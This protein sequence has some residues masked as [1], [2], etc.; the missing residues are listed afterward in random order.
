[1][2]GRFGTACRGLVLARQCRIVDRRPLILVSGIVWSCRRLH[3][4]P[5]FDSSDGFK[6]GQR[7]FARFDHAD[8]TT[9]REITHSAGRRNVVADLF[10]NVVVLLVSNYVRF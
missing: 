2:F 4:S 8:E 3:F 1:M 10:L 9:E 6:V 7:R 5:Q